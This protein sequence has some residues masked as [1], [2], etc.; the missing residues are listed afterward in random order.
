MFKYLEMHSEI[1]IIVTIIIIA[2]IAVLVV[3]SLP[4]EMPCTNCRVLKKKVLN[5]SNRRFLLLT[6]FS[7]LLKMYFSIQGSVILE[8]RKNCLLFDN[9]QHCKISGRQTGKKKN[10]FLFEINRI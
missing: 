9:I 6:P 3:K 4:V 5:G 10:H 2:I 8:C 1:F 7:Q